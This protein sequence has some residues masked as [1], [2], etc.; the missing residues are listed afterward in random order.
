MTITT[1]Y[2]TLLHFLQDTDKNGSVDRSE[3]CVFFAT[4]SFQS[5]RKKIGFILVKY[6][7]AW[8]YWELLT[9]LRKLLTVITQ[10]LLSVSSDGQVVTMIVIVLF[11]MGA[12]VCCNDDG[13]FALPPAEVSILA[14]DRR[15]PYRR[16]SSNALEFRL[17][18]LQL[19][20]LLLAFIGTKTDMSSGLLS[21]ILFAIVGVGV[22][23]VKNFF[24]AENACVR[25]T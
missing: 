1:S 3:F 10:L 24:K 14:W 12:Q 11:Y 17:L 15:G 6:K 23:F 18:S 25:H 2:D 22:R 5:W 16:E 8:K 20:Q 21:A 4:K 9:N 7:P 13:S 19:L